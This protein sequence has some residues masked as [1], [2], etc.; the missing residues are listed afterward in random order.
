MSAC[1][2]MTR[3]WVDRLIAAT[4][5]LSGSGL[6]A[7]MATSAPEAANRVATAKPMPLLPPVTIAARPDRLISMPF[8]Q[9]EQASP[10][11]SK[12]KSGTGV[13]VD[14]RVSLCS[15]RATGSHIAV[16]AFDG[17]ADHRCGDLIG[18][19]DVPDFAVALRGEVGEQFGDDRHV[20][21]LV[22]AQA[23]TAG[24]IF[25][26]RPPEHRQAVVEAVGAQLVKLRAVAAVVHRADEDTKALTLERLELLDMEQESAVAFEQHDLAVAAL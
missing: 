22:A 8:P 26:R 3:L 24:D 21:D 1:T 17:L 19:L 2:P 15:T 13:A 6:R 16:A 11:L 5:S 14:P 12:A 4:A 18:N 20:A 10:G 7:M 25:E 9:L 23:K